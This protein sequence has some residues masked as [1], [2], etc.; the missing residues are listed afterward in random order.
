VSLQYYKEG[1]P[2]DDKLLYGAGGLEILTWT[3]R[4]F[5]QIDERVLFSEALNDTQYYN[6]EA[7]VTY[8]GM[9][10]KVVGLTL[11]VNYVLDNALGLRAT[12]IPA[13][14]LFPGQAAFNVLAN[15]RAQ[16]IVNTGLLIKF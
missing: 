3:I 5:S 10:T 9:V 16:V 2:F 12:P 1:S 7:S 6:V 11:G 14:A 15:E 4:P 13:N 8:K